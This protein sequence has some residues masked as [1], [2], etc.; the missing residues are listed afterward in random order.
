MHAESSLGCRT[1]LVGCGARCGSTWSVLL[2]VVSGYFVARQNVGAQA[3]CSRHSAADGRRVIRE[4]VACCM[5]PVPSSRPLFGAAK[6]EGFFLHVAKDFC[7]IAR[8]VELSPL[9]DTIFERQVL[10]LA[11]ELPIIQVA[12]Q[13]PLMPSVEASFQQMALHEI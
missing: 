6:D 7:R 1:L 13:V 12:S 11:S 5:H 2:S 9:V 3:G 4:P 8:L 10:T